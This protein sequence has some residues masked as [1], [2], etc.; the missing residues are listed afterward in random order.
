[1][2]APEYGSGREVCATYL[3]ADMPHT[4]SRLE[5]AQFGLESV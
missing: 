3:A 1:M 5:L 2:Q 4:Y